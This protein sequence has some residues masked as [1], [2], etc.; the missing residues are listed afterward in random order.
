LLTEACLQ[1]LPQTL[2]L[3][4][5]TE[6]YESFGIT[7]AGVHNLKPVLATMRQARRLHIG[8]EDADFVRSIEVPIPPVAAWKYWVDPIERQRWACRHFSKNPDRVTR[9]AH[10]RVGRGTTM[11]CNHGPGTWSYEFVDWRPFVSFTVKVTAP[12]LGRYLGPRDEYETLDF[13]PTPGGGTRVVHRVRVTN[14]N[15]LSLFTYRLQRR[16]LAPVWR[17]W[18]QN[19][20]HVIA[21]D[22]AAARGRSAEVEA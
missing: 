16:G 17:R 5:H 10:G 3:P 22:S 13:V 12:H 20:L 7:T 15:N 8:S 18:E 6:Y 19:L 4:R 2:D 14:R 11:H 21:E 1:R 9:N